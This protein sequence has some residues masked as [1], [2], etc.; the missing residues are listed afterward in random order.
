MGSRNSSGTIFL[1]LS[2]LSS[3]GGEGAALYSVRAKLAIEG[4][5]EG[6]RGR[7]EEEHEASGTPGTS[8][9]SRP[10]GSGGAAAAAVPLGR[11]MTG[12]VERCETDGT[13][14][15]VR[16]RRRRRRSVRDQQEQ[17]LV[18]GR[19]PGA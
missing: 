4:V 12:M 3:D 1:I 5:R 8:A 19:E 15:W 6:V 18:D 10:L 11:A 7:G 16:G 9:A 2:R 17:E 14:G 13:R